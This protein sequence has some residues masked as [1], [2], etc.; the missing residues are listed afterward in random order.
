MSIE[1]Y[2]NQAAQGVASSFDQ[3]EQ[4]SFN[5]WGAA[6]TTTR[7]FQ[8]VVIKVDGKTQRIFVTIYLRWW[9]KMKYKRFNLIREIWLRR[10]SKRVKKQ[11]P[12]GWNSL[13]YYAQEKKNG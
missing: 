4:V 2:M 3:N 13:V 11:V 1:D 12:H 6:A 5:I 8:K 10:A 9:A 7:A